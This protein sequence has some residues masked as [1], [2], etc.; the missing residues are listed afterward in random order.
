MTAIT[1]CRLCNSTNLNEILN[2]GNLAFT[3]IFPEP[4]D[5][6]I[7]KTPLRLMWCRDCTLVQIGDDYDLGML[8]GD[9]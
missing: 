8:Y 6:P 5:S 4:V 9:N 3:G 7:E 2:L 1:R